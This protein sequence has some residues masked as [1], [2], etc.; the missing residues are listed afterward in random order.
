M[1]RADPA[2][3]LT[4]WQT[5]AGFKPPTHTDEQVSLLATLLGNDQADDTKIRSLKADIEMERYGRQLLLPRVGELAAA[6]A[7]FYDV[8]KEVSKASMR[9][10][11][12]ERSRMRIR[13]GENNLPVEAVLEEIAAVVLARR[14]ELDKAKIGAPARRMPL[15]RLMTDLDVI[16][17]G[18]R[19]STRPAARDLKSRDYWIS[20]ALQAVKVEHPSPEHHRS[21]FRS[22][23]RKAG[24][25]RSLVSS[26]SSIP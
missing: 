26:P 3:D 24:K 6:V 18:Y 21:E 22:L 11:Q 16:W 1:P 9:L 13:H 2:S 17:R 10:P 19:V 25:R 23:L 8:M 4:I 12:A 20:Q 15:R 5:Q 14:Q 7:Y